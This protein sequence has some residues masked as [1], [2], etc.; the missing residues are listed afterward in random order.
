[1]R[2]DRRLGPPRALIYIDPS[3]PARPEAIQSDLRGPRQTIVDYCNLKL[4]PS[5][6]SSPCYRKGPIRSAA[7]LTLALLDQFCD[8][9]D[10][11]STTS[12]SDEYRSRVTSR[13]PEATVEAVVP[14][15]AG[16]V[17]CQF[18]PGIA[19]DSR[20]SK[21]SIHSTVIDS[22]SQSALKSKYI[23]GETGPGRLELPDSQSMLR[24][25]PDNSLRK[26]A[27]RS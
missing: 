3:Q 1:M 26:L 24:E 11:R 2:G 13:I 5:P 12:T 22:T 10:R 23:P 6:E 19:S 15:P 9:K 7:R 27:Q 25:R 20:S 14:A 8:L 4:F 18:P 17:L 21:S 16:P